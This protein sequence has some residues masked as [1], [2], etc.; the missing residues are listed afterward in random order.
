MYK[1][2]LFNLNFW[3]HQVK[4]VK[5]IGYWKL[6]LEQLPI[7]HLSVYAQN[8]LF[9]HCFQKLCTGIPYFLYSFWNPIPFKNRSR[10]WKIFLHESFSYWKALQLS[11]FEENLVR[12]LS[13]SYPLLN[14]SWPCMGPGHGQA[15]VLVK[16]EAIGASFCKTVYD[17]P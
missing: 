13:W 5:I 10:F 6:P 4:L 16:T 15:W 1:N 17:A 14:Q 8:F 12:S 3:N 2:P 7:V 11:C 9:L